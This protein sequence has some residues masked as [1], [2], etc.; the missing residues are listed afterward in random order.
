[1]ETYILKK[2]NRKGK[3]F[4][5]E[6]PERGH[7]HHFGAE[8]GKTFIDGRSEKEKAAWEKRHSGDKGYNDKHSGIFYSRKLLWGPFPDLKK[9]AKALEK[10]LGVKIKVQL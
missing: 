8:G 5:L 3:R 4:V 9:S 1:M 2:S 6:M 7:K 10:E